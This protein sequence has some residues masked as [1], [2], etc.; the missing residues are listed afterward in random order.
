MT[1]IAER[2]SIDVDDGVADVQMIRA[3]KM[4]ALDPAMFEALVA[5]ADD[6]AQR[7]DVRAVV[8]SGKGRAF[9]AG[10]D[11]SALESLGQAGMRDRIAERTH[12]DANVFQ[13]VVLAWRDLPVPVI[14]AVHGV[15][16]GGGFQVMLGADLRFIEPQTK[17]SV[18]EVRWGLIPDMAGTALMRMLARDDVVRELTFTGRI[19]SGE[20]ALDLGF[21]TR[22]CADPH[23]EALTTALEIAT[24]SPDAIR[25]GKALLTAAATNTR[26]AQLQAESGIQNTLISGR[27]HAE[28]VAAGM[29]KRAPKFED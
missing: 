3:D 2:V 21:A 14:A 27:N 23:A 19:F 6:L 8:L 26:A 13:R 22:L 1:V 18:M 12:G 15:A 9:C 17:L 20:E 29:A 24:Y 11:M 16:F 5:A 25:A 4:N 7:R 10:I 28:A